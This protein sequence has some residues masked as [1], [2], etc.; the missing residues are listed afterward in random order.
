MTGG[1]NNDN[2]LQGRRKEDAN[3]Q[4]SKYLDSEDSERIICPVE[5]YADINITS[6]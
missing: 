1:M 3:D 4:G 6:K 5:G 2:T